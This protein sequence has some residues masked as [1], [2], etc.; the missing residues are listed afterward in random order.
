MNQNTLSEI[1]CI[2]LGF[3]I[4]S[5]RRKL[6]IEDLKNLSGDNIPPEKLASLG[7]KVICDPAELA[8]FHKLKKRAIR[9]CEIH[10]TRFLGG[11]AIPKAKLTNICSILEEIQKEYDSAKASFISRYNEII[12]SWL[13]ENDDWKSII[14]RAITP[15][16]VVKSRL[17]FSFRVFCVSEA[18]PDD[19]NDYGVIND[20]L[21][22][23]V[24]SLCGSLLKDVSKEALATWDTSF[25]GKDKLTRKALRPFN[26][27]RE[28]LD[29]FTFIDPRISP[30]VERIDLCLSSMPKTGPITGIHF[31]AL[32][33]L[34]L[35]ISD[36]KRLTAH[37]AS[38]IQANTEAALA[39]DFIDENTDIDDDTSIT[40]DLSDA[41][42]IPDIP[43]QPKTS[44]ASWGF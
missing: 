11:Y 31:V 21:S 17:D 33:S 25:R 9:A 36:E 12:S 32:E 35:L 1:R 18:V 37:G 42:V 4:W 43:F 3:R 41:T 8:I 7:S 30:I 10:G 38:V 14:S 39:T 22:N 27:L 2:D 26:T 40:E 34:I 6:R 20:G 13:S 5:A 15:L 19:D 28:K 44:E 23:H 24:D 29:G 16:D